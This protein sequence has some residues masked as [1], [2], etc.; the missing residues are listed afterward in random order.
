[1]KKLL[2]GVTLG[3]TFS[4][5]AE[6]PADLKA[7]NDVFENIAIPQDS[8]DEYKFVSE[9]VTLVPDTNAA[10]QILQRES[11]DLIESEAGIETF[12]VTS[13]YLDKDA[14]PEDNLFNTLNAE[15]L[16]KRLYVEDESY[17]YGPYFCGAMKINAESGEYLA[18]NCMRDLKTLT[19][20]IQ[21]LKLNV[22]LTE[23]VGNS[24]GDLKYNVLYVHSK[25]EDGKI[26]RIYF[27]VL[28]EI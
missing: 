23:V 17:E 4:A 11:T 12:K 15:Q 27:D 25:D 19:Q 7:V 2:L 20:K 16:A 10:A 13:L 22:T 14:K 9:L 8:Q 24:W 5:N 28:H 3:L 1:M 21:D 26:L 6:L 18:Q